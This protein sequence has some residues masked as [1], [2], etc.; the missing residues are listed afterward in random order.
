MYIYVSLC[1]KVRPFKKTPLQL[2][3]KIIKRI[4]LSIKKM[5]LKIKNLLS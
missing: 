3:N 2:K 1:R 4:K 5:R